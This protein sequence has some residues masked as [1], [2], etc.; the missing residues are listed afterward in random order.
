METNN[1]NYI[2]GLSG[3]RGSGKDTFAQLIHFCDLKFNYPGYWGEKTFDFFLNGDHTWK[4]IWTNR[5]FAKKLKE[6]SALIT[7]FPDQY[8]QD[9]K[10]TFLPDWGMTIGQI[11]QKIGTDAIRHGLHDEAW[12]IACFIDIGKGEKAIITDMRFP[13]EM[14]AIENRGGITIRIDGDPKNQQGD[15]KRDDNHPSETSLDDADFDIHVINN[16]TLKDLEEKA[17][18]VLELIPRYSRKNFPKTIIL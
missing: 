18:I 2:V 12:I 8:S 1:E 3:R 4:S 6:V 15:G 10:A 14:E 17:K 11:Q 9:G 5:S 13:N 16:S 7:G